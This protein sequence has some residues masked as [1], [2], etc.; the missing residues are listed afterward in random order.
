MAT[1]TDAEIADQAAY[2]DKLQRDKARDSKETNQTIKD[3]KSRLTQ[4]LDDRH[5]GQMT[6][7]LATGEVRE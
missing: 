7:D 1:V 2:L 3:A 5:S 4:L 6:M